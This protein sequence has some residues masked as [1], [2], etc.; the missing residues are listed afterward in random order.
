[1]PPVLR[2]LSRTVLGGTALTLA[3]ALYL[4]HRTAADLEARYPPCPPTTAGTPALRDT[5]A[6]P[7]QHTPYT[8]IYSARVPVHGLH[9]LAAAASPT[10]DGSG[11][12]SPRTEESPTPAPSLEDA[13]ARAFL[14]SPALHWEARLL[15]RTR[16]AG[17]TGAHGFARGRP[18]LNGLFTVLRTPAAGA[19]LLV[20]WRM[21]GGATAFFARIAR[22]GYPWRLMDGGRHE[23]GV[24]EVGADGTVE[25]RFACAHQYEIWEGEGEGQKTVPEWV[26]RAHRVFAMW[27]LDERARA[28]RECALQ[29]GRTKTTLPVRP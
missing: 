28:V 5:S 6:T 11:P 10:S 14:Q 27:L 22:V 12:P 24:G 18:L 1:M 16:D 4:Y 17:D 3:P 25:V 8:D 7:S 15:G 29:D 19:P 2:T 23:W 20:E 13:W 26:K 21:D 9:A